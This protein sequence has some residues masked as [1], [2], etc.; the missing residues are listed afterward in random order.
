MHRLSLN[1]L[2]IRLSLEPQGALLIR[3]GELAADGTRPEAAVVRTG[4]RETPFLPGSALKGALRIQC[5]RIARA[6]AGAEPRRMACD[7][8]ARRGSC[9]GLLAPRRD[10]TGPQ[11]Y[12]ESCFVCRLFGNPLVAARVRVSDAIP[13]E[14]P[15]V[16]V[17]SSIG[18]DRTF[19]AVAS[20][21]FFQ[22]VVTDARFDT[23]ITV[24]NFTLA[25]AG[26]VAFALADLR[27]GLVALGSGRSRGYGSVRV[28]SAEIV[29]Q[30]PQAVLQDGA[31]CTMRGREL[32]S[33][34]ALIGAGALLAGWDREQYRLPS[35]GEVVP[36]ETSGA[37]ESGS[38]V[39]VPL[40]GDDPIATLAAACLGAWRT[41]VH[42][43]ARA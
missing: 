34:P 18:I 29:A 15:R 16:E 10:L 31:I 30:Y 13:D 27:D 12:L 14:P 3:A 23:A 40:G 28:V 19:G 5:E 33:A 17:R 22:E 6:A 4:A 1:A 8:L 37:A 2:H 43:V 25:Q 38:S 24:S 11:L 35:E 26:L 7:P 36:V 9:G 21:P 41:A 39:R 20:G 32:T 42:E